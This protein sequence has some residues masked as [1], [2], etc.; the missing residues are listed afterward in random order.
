[1]VDPA[2]LYRQGEEGR[3][4]GIDRSTDPEILVRFRAEFD[5]AQ[6]GL[7]RDF[8]L[9]LATVQRYEDRGAPRWMSYAMVGW[10]I[11]EG[12]VSPEELRPLWEGRFR[13]R[14]RPLLERDVV[15]RWCRVFGAAG[16][17]EVSHRSERAG[18]SRVVGADARLA[19]EANQG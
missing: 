17:E 4:P 19:A 15:E 7:G 5:L 16:R 3:M 12:R 6:E 2:G 1:M 18:A 10:S 14:W 11:V 9:S 8:G 13:V